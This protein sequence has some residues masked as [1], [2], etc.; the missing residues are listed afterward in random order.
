MASNSL[1]SNAMG[2]NALASNALSENALS[3][4][5]LNTE[6]T[7]AEKHIKLIGVV[8]VLSGI[9]IWIWG[10]THRRKHVVQ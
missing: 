7:V 8:L 5:E 3:Q 2:S 6:I 9:A 10:H 4:N 1:A